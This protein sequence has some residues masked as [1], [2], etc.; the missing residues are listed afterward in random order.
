MKFIVGSFATFLLLFAIYFIYL[1]EFYYMYES[2]C[3]HVY[4]CATYMEVLTDAG[5]YI[6]CP[7]TGIKWC[8]ICVI[9]F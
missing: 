7:G 9:A 2:V 3:L 8:E 6:G 4:K 1:F 5:K